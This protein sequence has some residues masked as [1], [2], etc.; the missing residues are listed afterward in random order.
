MI[1]LTASFYHETLYNL[2]V[3]PVLS[4]TDALHRVVSDIG[5][6][7][8]GGA[9]FRR[10][11]NDFS[12]NA[13]AGLF[14]MTLKGANNTAGNNPDDSHGD[15]INSGI[16][17]GTIAGIVIGALSSV[18]LVCFGVYFR[19]FRHRTRLRT[20]SGSIQVPEMASSEVQETDTNTWSPTTRSSE[21]N[22]REA[23]DLHDG[24][25]LHGQ[26]PLPPE[27][28]CVRVRRLAELGPHVQPLELE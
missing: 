25:R 11:V 26:K 20:S 24:R 12:S 27:P 7:S 4:L 14:R 23:V 2:H 6:N 18:G 13:L 28:A 21:P 10:P 22:G 9:T 1:D 5:G 3:P 19:F 17:G 15:D 16:S 8:N